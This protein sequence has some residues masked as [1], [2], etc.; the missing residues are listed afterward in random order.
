MAGSFC[1]KACHI[2]SLI[3]YCVLTIINIRPS[4]L[5]QIFYVKLKLNKFSNRV[6]LKHNFQMVYSRFRDQMYLP[7]F[8]LHP[9]VYFE[10]FVRIF[11]SN[12]I[13]LRLV[14]R[15]HGRH[16]YCWICVSESIKIRILIL[17]IRIYYLFF[18]L[19]L[20]AKLSFQ[21]K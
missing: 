14:A 20:T 6:Y 2:P 5:V 15:T 18:D 13:S 21:T 4:K 7:L 17:Y 12:L 19:K 1:V 3:S 8:H 10:L 16:Y 11:R 9:T